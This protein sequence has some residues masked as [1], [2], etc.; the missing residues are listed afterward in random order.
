MTQIA[1]IRHYP[2]AWNAEARLQGQS[3]IPLNDASRAKLASLALPAPW[4]QARIV[5]SPLKRA[6]ET[7][8][9]LAGGFTKGSGASW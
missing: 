2:T 5:A 9:L 1:L 8:Q 7:A 6:E 3:D 4:D